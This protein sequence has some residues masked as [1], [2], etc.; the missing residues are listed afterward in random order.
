MTLEWKHCKEKFKT[1]KRD[2]KVLEWKL[3]NAYYFPVWWYVPKTF[4]H[5]INQ[6]ED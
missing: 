3:M 1:D 2:K 5:H 4:G 6:P